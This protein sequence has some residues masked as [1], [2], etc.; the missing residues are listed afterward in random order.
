MFVFWEPTRLSLNARLAGFDKMFRRSSFP[1]YD[2][3]GHTGSLSHPLL[4]HHAYRPLRGELSS[5]TFRF[6]GERGFTGCEISVFRTLKCFMRQSCM[7]NFVKILFCDTRRSLCLDLRQGEMFTRVC[8]TSDEGK[9]FM[10]KIAATRLSVWHPQSGMKGAIVTEGQ[11]GLQ[12]KDAAYD[13]PDPHSLPAVLPY[14]SRTPN[15]CQSLWLQR[16]YFLLAQDANCFDGSFP[17]AHRTTK[18]Y[19]SPGSR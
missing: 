10:A 7:H 4:H 11:H 13:T 15:A 3:I 14:C 17:L 16:S 1:S 9:V 18:D 8:R 2:N 6:G 19:S 5:T 12:M